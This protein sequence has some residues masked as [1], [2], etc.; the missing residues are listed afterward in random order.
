M[1][2]ECTAVIYARRVIRWLG[3]FSIDTCGVRFVVVRMV[4]ASIC[5]MS[6]FLTLSLPGEYCSP[7]HVRIV[8][9]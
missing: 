5:V 8:I 9:N 2:A 3:L 4:C 7:L 1:L 6:I